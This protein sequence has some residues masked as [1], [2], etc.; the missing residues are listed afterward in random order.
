MFNVRN[1]IIYFYEIK[2]DE[3]KLKKIRGNIISKYSELENVYIKNIDSESAKQ[4]LLNSTSTIYNLEV[5]K[6]PAEEDSYT[7]SYTK[8]IYPPIIKTLDK[9]LNKEL[10]SFEEIKSIKNNGLIGKEY[11]ESIISCIDI[12]ETFKEEF[13]NQEEYYSLLGKSKDKEISDSANILKRK[14]YIQ[15]WG[16]NEWN[17]K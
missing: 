17:N 12:I 3:E 2:V 1:N 4:K 14:L 15:E 10:T 5:E 7:I 11:Y 13:K 8:I 9:I 6:N 16:N